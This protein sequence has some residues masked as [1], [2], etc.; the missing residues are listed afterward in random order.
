MNSQPIW[1]HCLL[2]AFAWLFFSWRPFPG[3]CERQHHLWHFLE[4]WRQE[5]WCY[6]PCCWASEWLWCW[7]RW[8][9]TD[10]LLGGTPGTLLSKDTIS[11]SSTWQCKENLCFKEFQCYSVYET[12]CTCT[13]H[14]LVVHLI[15]N[16]ENRNKIKTLH[17]SFGPSGWDP[18][19]EVRWY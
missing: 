12:N 17:P 13:I 2:T 9:W 1:S 8:Q 19:G 7:L 4:P 5:Q 11:S 18:Q 14:N 3:G 16:K 6:G 15:C 10:H